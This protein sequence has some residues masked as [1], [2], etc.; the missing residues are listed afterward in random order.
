M[1]FCFVS[2]KYSILQIHSLPDGHSVLNP[3]Y[4]FFSVAGENLVIFISNEMSFHP[5]FTWLILTAYEY[6]VGNI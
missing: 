1:I 5:R 4:N 2:K 3:R 6:P